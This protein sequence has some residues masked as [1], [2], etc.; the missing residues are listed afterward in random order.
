[1]SRRSS[2]WVAWFAGA[3]SL[4]V[5]CGS[6][7]SEKDGAGGA[8]AS[9]GGSSGGSVTTGGRAASGGN[10][11]GSGGIV[12]TGG[13]E[14]TGGS[15]ATGGT[16]VSGGT[17]GT[18]TG[19]AAGSG[20]AAGESGGATD[21]GQCREVSRFRYATGERSFN[22]YALRRLPDGFLL[23]D[24]GGGG[25]PLVILDEAGGAREVSRDLAAGDPSVKPEK[26]FVAGTGQE[27]RF[28]NIR[29]LD[30]P[31]VNQVYKGYFYVQSFLESGEAVGPERQVLEIFMRGT[32]LNYF[33]SSQDGERVVLANLEPVIRDPWMVLV[34]KDGER[35][36]EGVRVLDTGDQ[37]LINCFSV[38]GTLHGALGF[39][40]DDGSD[41]LRIVELGAT[42]EIVQALTREQTLE[43]PNV[44]VDSSGIYVLLKETPESPV[45]DVYRL[46]DS[47][48]TKIMSLP[49]DESSG[50][51]GWV[52]GGAQPLLIH[53]SGQDLAFARWK[54]DKLVPLSGTFP[55]ELA[56]VAS[57]GRIFFS[58]FEEHAVTLV[59]VTCGLAE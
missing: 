17:P 54:D 12:I 26:W 55:G 35:I 11:S 56:A 39:A 58:V 29:R 24:G 23:D 16:T 48:L 57:D 27:P 50:Y 5:G 10:A 36:S 18:T 34:S 8:S 33:A 14:A 42:G 41:R 37:P 28:L 32:A 45:P 2:V 38:L 44:S 22:I 1:M 13:R 51:Y 21:V 46:E 52:A 15:D 40:R 6:S 31:D 53:R 20:G 7:E 43:C 49:R 19:G 25:Y 47:A 4:G 30:D 3:V 9:E 59:G